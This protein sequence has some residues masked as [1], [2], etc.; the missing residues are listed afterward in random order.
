MS[1]IKDITTNKDGESY[2][3]IRIIML[4][5]FVTL[6]FG[7]MASLFLDYYAYF[8]SLYYGLEKPTVLPHF[9]AIG[10]GTAVSGIALGGGAGIYAKKTT[11]PN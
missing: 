9:D 2:C 3:P 7:V 8:Y 5:S 4:L 10:Y 1:V 6:T 11:E